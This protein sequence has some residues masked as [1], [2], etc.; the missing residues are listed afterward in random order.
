MHLADIK[1]LHG[2]KPEIAGDLDTMLGL[3]AQAT[4][5]PGSICQP[6]LRHACPFAAR[7]SG[8]PTVRDGT[9][10]RLRPWRTPAMPS[11]LSKVHRKQR[12]SRGTRTALS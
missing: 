3:G 4:S 1:I 10:S 2:Q 6:S 5:R 11:Y 8:R 9:T 12:L 7:Y